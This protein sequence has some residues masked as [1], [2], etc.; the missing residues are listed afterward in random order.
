LLGKLRKR[1]AKVIEKRRH[2]RVD[3]HYQLCC[4]PAGESGGSSC[5]GHAVNASPGGLYFRTANCRCPLGRIVEVEL[6]IPPSDGRLHR[7]G[8]ISSYA[9]LL[10]VE[11]DSP[12]PEKDKASD[13]HYGVAVQF[14]RAPKLAT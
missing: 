6:A 1:F 9:K 12:I 3:V 8:R 13:T 7:P 2:S 4:R 10:R 11:P 14:C 5:H